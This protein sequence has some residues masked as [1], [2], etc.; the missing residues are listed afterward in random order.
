MDLKPFFTT[1]HLS[2]GENMS[3]LQTLL[4]AIPTAEDS[5][6][7]TAD[8]HNSLRAALLLIAT[9]LGGSSV[10]EEIT[11]TFTPVFFSITDAGAKEPEWVLSA[12][13]A[14]RPPDNSASGWFPLELPEDARISVLTVIGQRSGN[15][16]QCSIRLIRQSL[17]DASSVPLIIISL[18][19]VTGQP[20]KVSGQIGGQSP[21]LI[22]D[23]Q[24][25]D[26]SKY[27]YL[28]QANLNNADEDA[29]V[30][31][32]SFQLTLVRS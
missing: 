17:V 21:V 3:D 10:S 27:K 12:G 30:D 20:F 26:N 7:I 19:N 9:Q 5:H 1:D 2:K 32:W 24:K 6:V 31:L 29:I 28:V 8:Y 22:Q 18:K 16:K 4:D 14:S 23:L 15:V 11:L 13:I 25:V